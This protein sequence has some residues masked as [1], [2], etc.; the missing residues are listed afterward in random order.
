M[1]LSDL[2]KLQDIAGDTFP[3]KEGRFLFSGSAEISSGQQRHSITSSSKIDG[4]RFRSPMQGKVVQSRLDGF[5]FNK[6]KPYESW[7]IFS[8]EARKLW[9]GYCQI[10][11]PK[12]I[13]GIS[14]RYINRIDLSL[15]IQM[16]EWFTTR[17]ELGP[18]IPYMINSFLMRMEIANDKIRANGIVTETVQLLT[19]ERAAII[20][21]IEVKKKAD[22][23][24]PFKELWT[25]SE[26]LRDFKNMIF[27]NS[28][29][30]KTMELLK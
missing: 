11:S 9:E 30:D 14:L 19:D 15:P 28:I 13:R 26:K 18:K 25:I 10:T 8:S 12:S 6:L 4:F 17:P 16:E 29:T 21:D 2:E 1:T 23:L 24:P 20:L 3:E 22:I 5:A 27:F 7:P